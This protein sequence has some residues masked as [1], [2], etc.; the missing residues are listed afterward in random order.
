VVDYF[1]PSDQQALDDNDLD[2]GSGGVLILPNSVG[3]TVYPH[4][5]ISAGKEGTI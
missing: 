3:S 4:L 1:T 2:L 5:L